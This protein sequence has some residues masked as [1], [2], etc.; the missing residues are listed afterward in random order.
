MLSK[1][2]C[3]LSELELL[4]PET[5]PNVCYPRGI[6]LRSPDASGETRAKIFKIDVNR[7]R[8]TIKRPQFWLTGNCVPSPKLSN[9]RLCEGAY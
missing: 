3:S 5:E 7:N 9:E 4:Q 8:K 1:R 2:V 6:L